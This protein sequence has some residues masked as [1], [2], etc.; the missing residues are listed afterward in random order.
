[1]KALLHTA[2]LRLEYT[3]VPDP[4]MGPDDVL[5]RVK[6]CGI[7]GSD[8]HGYTGA[9]GRRIPPIIMGHEAAGIVADAGE[10]VAGLRPGDRVCVNSTIYC[11]ECAACRQGQ[12]NRCARRQV[13]GVSLPGNRRDGAFAELVAVPWWIVQPMPVPLT[14]TQAALLEP[15][16]I[17]VHAVNRAEVT[18]GDAVV[19]IGS[20]AIGLFILQA[21]RLKGAGTLIVSDLNDERLALAKML[22]ADAVVN[23]QRDDLAARVRALTDGRGADVSFEA[24]GFSATLREALAVTRTGGCV[25][26][27]GNLEKTTSIDLQDL[28]AR[29]LTLRGTYASSGEY[30]ACIDLVASGQIDV[31]P[32]VS[33]TQPLSEGQ[34][35]FDRLREGKESLLKIIL[36][37]G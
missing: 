3:E 34:R 18:A 37:P 8:V 6:A 20:G 17:A 14:F 22:G 35:A 23:P 33:E 5:V 29:E 15:V 11:N 13:L 30:R 2:P 31:L 27:V 19:I 28:V 16:S 10:G 25:T 32:L 7:C 4:T 12:Y 24:V 26:A 36:E 1:M 21:A 9:T